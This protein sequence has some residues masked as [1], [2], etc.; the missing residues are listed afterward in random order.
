MARPRKEINQIAFEKLCGLQC[1]EKEICDFFG[2]DDMTLARWCKRTYG[3]RFSEVF[4]MKRGAGKVSL[5]RTQWQLAEKSAAMAIFLGK[6]YL[7]QSDK[8]EL[9]EMERHRIEYDKKMLELREREI[10]AKEQGW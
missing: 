9:T 3:K 4:R 7:G 10:A 8:Q 2:V 1:T 6:Q 5:R